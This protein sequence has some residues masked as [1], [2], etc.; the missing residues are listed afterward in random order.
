[1]NDFTANRRRRFIHL[2]WSNEQIFES[3]CG[4]S[5]IKLFW[6]P[7]PYIMISFVVRWQATHLGL[8][9]VRYAILNKLALNLPLFRK[10]LPNALRDEV[11]FLNIYTTYW[12]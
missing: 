2:F 6:K 12:S 4:W 11:P 8:S 1:L 3:H 5:V 10:N 7:L 9:W